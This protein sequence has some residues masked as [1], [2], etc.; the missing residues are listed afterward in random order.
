LGDLQNRADQ[1]A[2]QQKKFENGLKSATGQTN[3]QA[4]R[5]GPTPNMS[6]DQ[7]EAMAAEEDRLLSELKK[8]ENDI[9]KQGRD[10]RASQPEASSRLR[11]GLSEIQQNEVERRMEASSEWI[12]S[13]QG[14]QIVQWQGPVTSS[15]DSL[16]QQVARAQ[17]ALRDGNQQGAAQDDRQRQLANLEQTRAQIQQL[18]QQGQGKQQGN[19][20]R[21]G[22]GKQGG[23]KQGDGKQGGQGQGQGQQPGQGQGQGQGQQPG[24]GQAQGGGQQPNNAGGGGGGVFGGNYNG[25]GR[26]DDGRYPAQGNYDP[27]GFINNNPLDPNQVIRSA[28][29]QLNELRQYFKNNVD[30]TRQ[31]SQVEQELQRVNVGDTASALLGERLSRTVLPQLETLELQVRREVDQTAGGQVRSGGSDKMPDGF[32]DQAAEYFRNLN[33]TISK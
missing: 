7:A 25:G 6:R 2:E 16:R 17:Q 13:G 15:L 5:T 29:G 30:V 12:R 19:Q 28:Q 8:L 10:L 23:G 26:I 33:K 1:L 18:A 11:D 22:D 21:G 14:A 24:Q 27:R 20:G 9:Q 3:P 31:I 32:A 4:P